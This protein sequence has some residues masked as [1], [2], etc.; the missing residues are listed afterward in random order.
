MFRL[1]TKVTTSPTASRPQ[2]VGHLGDGGHLGAPGGEQGDDLVLADLVAGPNPLED[3]G[4]R[5]RWPTAG[6][7]RG[8]AGRPRRRSTSGRPAPGPR[9][10]CGRA[11]GSA[12]PRPASVRRRGRTRGRSSGEGRARGRVASVTSRRRSTAGQ[13]RS[14]LTWSAVTGETPP[15]SSMPASSSEP[16]S[17][18]RLGGAWR[19][20][21]GGR[22]SRARA[23]ASRKSS[24]G[25]GSALCI[26]VPALGRKF[27]TMTSCTWPWRRWD[28][29]MAS[30]ASTRSCR[31][32]PMPTR[33]PVVN[34]MASSPAASRVARR[35]SGSLSGEPSWAGTGGQGLEHHPLRRGDGPQ[36]GQ[37]V[38]VQG[39]GVGVGEEAGLVEHQPAH[40][41]EVVDGRGVAVLVEPLA[42]RGVALLGPLAEGEQRLVAAGLGAGPGDGQD[43]VGGQVRGL[44]PGRGGG[45]RAVRTA[46]AAQPGQRDEDLRRVRHPPAVGQVPHR[47]GLGQEVRQGPLQQLGRR[48]AREPYRSLHVVRTQPLPTR[49]QG[50][51][52]GVRRTGL[53]GR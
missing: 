36:R 14:G 53:R 40:G 24:G 31:V 6:P 46:V 22:I 26:A 9:R 19:W 52:T 42:G 28:A 7:G 23:M 3:G 45:E 47:R 43:L 13:G 50:E 18:D 44:D 39:A 29:A 1:W 12:G 38:G 41:D 33:I 37:L 25:H 35:R 10:R 32:S 30:R 51:Q 49:A 5:A 16:K 17:S 21:S 34:G 15:Q 48:H 11:R 20:T 27:W 4:D 8:S 2:L